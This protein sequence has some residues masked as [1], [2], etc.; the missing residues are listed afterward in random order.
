MKPFFSGSLM[1]RLSEKRSTNL[2]HQFSKN[3]FLLFNNL[4]P[5]SNDGNPFYV[6]REQIRHHI[7][8]LSLADKSPIFL[9][10]E[11]E[12]AYWA[13]D[14]S[15]YKVSIHGSWQDARTYFPNLKQADASILGHARSLIAWNA[16]HQYC[17]KCGTKTTATDWG[18]KKECPCC[19]TISYPRMDPVVIALVINKAGDSCLLGRGIRHPPELYSCLAGFLEPGESIEDAVVREV[20]EESNIKYVAYLTFRVN[21]VRYVSSQPW[22]FPY[23][24]MIGCF[25]TAESDG[26]IKCADGELL[27]VAWFPKEQIVNALNGKGKLL[28]PKPHAIAHSILKQWVKL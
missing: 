13:L 4:N 12:V 18:H 28:V 14:V 7:P 2:L 9:G 3:L 17:S 1:N 8:N 21:H 19:K 5:L 23:Q 22:P 10:L 20:L 26:P 16:D 6:T 15:S 25:A 27:D 24:L 11:N